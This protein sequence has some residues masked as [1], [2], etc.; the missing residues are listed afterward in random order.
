[1]KRC[2]FWILRVNIIIKYVV[3]IALSFPLFF[4]HLPFQPGGA[5]DLH[6]PCTPSRR[7]RAARSLA[8]LER[9]IHRLSTA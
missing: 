7:E 9:V 5:P 3:I 8:V 6:A 2:R 4:P 1:M